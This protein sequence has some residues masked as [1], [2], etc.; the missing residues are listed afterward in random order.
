MAR[1]PGPPS[2]ENT[3]VSSRA[4][5]PPPMTASFVTSWHEL[6]VG[7]LLV[8]RVVPWNSS[9]PKRICASVAC[10]RAAGGAGLDV[11]EQEPLPADSP[12]RACPNTIL[13]SHTAWYSTNSIIRLRELAAME[14]VRLIEGAELLHIVN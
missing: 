10:S 9:C 14:I 5:T 7:P 13:T 2:R 3:V 1:T 12:L 8:K 4:S 6:H 11:Y